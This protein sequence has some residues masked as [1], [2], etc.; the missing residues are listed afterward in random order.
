MKEHPDKHIRAAIHYAVE[1]GW[2][3]IAAGSSAHCFGRLKCGT[4]DHREHMMSVWSTPSVP[5]NHARQIIRMVDRCTDTLSAM[6]F[7]TKEV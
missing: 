5:V 1:Q 4:P 6:V 2:I 7:D 3:F